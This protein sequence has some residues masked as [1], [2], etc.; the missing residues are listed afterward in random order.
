MAKPIDIQD[1]RLPKGRA[2]PVSGMNPH[3]AAKVPAGAYP[4]SEKVVE[5][6]VVADTPKALTLTAGTKW[7]IM[8][9][10]VWR[11]GVQTN[12]D[13]II[14]IR[15]TLPMGAHYNVITLTGAEEKNPHSSDALSIYCNFT[16]T[17]GIWVT[18]WYSD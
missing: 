3:P 5:T 9:V 15:G 10:E 1:V 18:Y 2:L 13:N 11:S 8:Q 14:A 7:T 12:A 16:D 17:V 4:F 6:S